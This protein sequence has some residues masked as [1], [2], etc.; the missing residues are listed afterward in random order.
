MSEKRTDIKELGEFGLIDHITGA[1][2]LK[3]PSSILGVGDD[4]ALVDHTGRHTVMTSD[5]LLEGIHFDLSY[6]PLRHLGFKSVAVNISDLAAMNAIPGQI[7]VNIGL[8]NRFSVEAVEELYKGI[9]AACEAYNVD[10]V[11]G[12]T[13]S[14]RSGLVIS[15]TAVGSVAP[16][17][18]VKR[19][20]AR[21]NDIVCVTGDLGAAYLGLQILEREKQ[22]YMANPDMQPKISEYEYLVQRQL[23]PNA[24]MDIIHDFRERSLVPTSMIDVSDGLA[25]E[26]FHLSK[27]SA[28]GFRIFEDK[29]PLDKQAY[30]TAVEFNM[31]P[32]TCA[33]NGGEDYELL[34][35]ISQEDHEKV[36]DHPDIHFIGQV[37]VQENVNEMVTKGE[38]VIPLKAQG[39]DHY[40]E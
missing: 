39:W 35:T 3:Q 6:M 5:M 17:D 37:T 22:V 33:L 38:N 9:E 18:A 32:T 12:D 8:S 13:T 29:L 24:R 11:G 10:L 25:S 27:N 34:F 19:S 31:N 30:D 7:L 1:F 23:R 36:K 26:I 21:P 14:S 15:I 40:G 4:A 2:S 28:V 16:D 20:G